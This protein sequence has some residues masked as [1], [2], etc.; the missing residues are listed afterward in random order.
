MDTDSKEARSKCLSIACLVVRGLPGARVASVILWPFYRA[1]TCG[2]RGALDL[3]CGQT[4][5]IPFLIINFCKA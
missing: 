3:S 5:G 2:L 4:G 1:S